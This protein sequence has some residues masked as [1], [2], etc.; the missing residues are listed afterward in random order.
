MP[1][2][3]AP[4]KKAPTYV[5]CGNHTVDGVKPG[6]PIVVTADRAIVL[7]MAGHIKES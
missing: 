6:D 5:V 4:A 1:A 2:K 3:K 7:L